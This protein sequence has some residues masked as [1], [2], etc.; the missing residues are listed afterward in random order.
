M[1]APCIALPFGAVFADQA[2]RGGVN[3]SA[4]KNVG[5]ADLRKAIRDVQAIE[6]MPARAS[7]TIKLEYLAL[8]DVGERGIVFS[9]PQP[10]WVRS[11]GYPAQVARTARLVVANLLSQADRPKYRR[12]PVHPGQ[13]GLFEL[14]PAAAPDPKLR[15]PAEI[16]AAAVT[17]IDALAR[18]LRA[19]APDAALQLEVVD[20]QLQMG[21]LWEACLWQDVA[22]TR[23]D[24][25]LLALA[26]QL[27]YR[28][29]GEFPA[30]LDELVK[31]GYLK[32][33]PADPFGKGEPFH[34]RRGAAPQSEAVLWSVWR[35][36]IDQ[37]GREDLHWGNGDWIVRVRVPGTVD[38]PQLKH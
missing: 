29:H 7:D 26:L 17:K 18:T 37:G 32:S 3:W 24:G 11:T 22:E 35:D 30:S 4:Q 28:E 9:T 14:D 21:N 36:G 19:V 34:Y 15:P 12:T 27:H 23:R 16:E 1:H 20:P 25:L 5:A 2:V 8:R 6:E 33:I 31:N 38:E 10:S 13:L